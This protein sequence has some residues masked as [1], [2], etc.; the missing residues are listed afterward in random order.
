MAGPENKT[1]PLHPK[2]IQGRI[3]YTAHSCTF[4]QYVRQSYYWLLL[5][6]PIGSQL[7]LIAFMMHKN[8]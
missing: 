2:N 7:T 6:R 5:P 8:I 1:L 3:V 4:V